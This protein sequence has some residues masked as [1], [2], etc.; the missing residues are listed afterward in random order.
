MKRLIIRW[1]PE[2]SEITPYKP[3]PESAWADRP[4]LS[5]AFDWN[6]GESC[7]LALAALVAIQVYIGIGAILGALAGLSYVWSALVISSWCFPGFV[8]WLIA[9]AVIASQ[10]VLGAVM[11]TFLWL[12]SLIDWYGNGPESF[13]RWLLPGLFATCG[14]PQ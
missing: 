5:A 7:T 11:R 6:A 12:P 9:C 1:G 4:G 2:G 8:G 14:G 13:A 3:S 10:L